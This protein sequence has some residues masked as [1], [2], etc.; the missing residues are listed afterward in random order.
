MVPV[1]LRGWRL[2]VGRLAAHGFQVLLNR[3]LVELIRIPL[4]DPD[5]V[6]GT[7]AEAGPEAVAEVVGGEDRL[8]VHDADGALGA[9][10]DAEAAA[11]ALLFVDLYDFSDHWRGFSR[12]LGSWSWLIQKK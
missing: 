4:D 8:A 2:M 7:V 3:L 6:L 5:G 11:V 1:G 10:R 12:S 9:D